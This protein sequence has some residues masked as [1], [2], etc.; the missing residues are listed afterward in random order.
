MKH[1]VRLH[2]VKMATASI[3]YFLISPKNFPHKEEGSLSSHRIRGVTCKQQIMIHMI[4]CKSKT[5]SEEVMPHLQCSLGHMSL[6]TWARLSWPAI[7]RA[8]W[9]GNTPRLRVGSL[10]VSLSWDPSRQPA[11]PAG[12]V[13]EE[14]FRLL[15]P[16][17]LRGQVSP[18]Y[19][20]EYQAA[21]TH[22]SNS[23]L[24]ELL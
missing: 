18:A 17:L 23:V 21:N 20:S 15:V 11:W 24:S 8:S 12:H 2:H 13:S 10:A 16:Q 14:A 22:Y 4:L 3:L 5:R 19:T 6:E 7:L 9:G 1:C